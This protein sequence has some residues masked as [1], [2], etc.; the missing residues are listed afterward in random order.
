MSNDE[1]TRHNMFCSY[2]QDTVNE[3]N[4]VLYYLQGAREKATQER[5]PTVHKYAD[6]VIGLMTEIQSDFGFEPSSNNTHNFIL[7]DKS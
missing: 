3:L 7:G 2:L 6:T 4:E 1:R 5:L